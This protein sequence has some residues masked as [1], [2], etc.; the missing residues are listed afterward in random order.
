MS[1]LALEPFCESQI[2]IHM[3]A[4]SDLGDALMT[5]GLAARVIPSNRSL[6]FRWLAMSSLEM[7][8]PLG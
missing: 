8:R 1:V 6:F 5:H 2:L 7:A 4:M 3:M